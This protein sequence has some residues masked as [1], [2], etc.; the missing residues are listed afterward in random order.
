MTAFGGRPPTAPIRR[1]T[2]GCTGHAGWGNA[3][4][5]TN[6]G[7]GSY[8]VVRPGD[9]MW[10]ISAELGTT[11]NRLAAANGIANSDVI[12]VGQRIYY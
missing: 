10:E 8:Y 4:D 2:T 12:S 1:G 9:T 6:A 3:A 11:V 5:R 7:G